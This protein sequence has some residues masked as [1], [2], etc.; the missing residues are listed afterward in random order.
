MANKKPHGKGRRGNKANLRPPWKP[1][2]SGNPSGRP[3]RRPITDGYGEMAREKM[4]PEL[5]KQLRMK[6]GS[7][8]AQA[9]ARAL[10]IKAMKG[11]VRSA[12][13]IRQ[14]I[15]GSTTQ[16]LKNEM[17]DKQRTLEEILE[18]SYRVEGS[19]ENAESF[20]TDVSDTNSFNGPLSSEGDL[21]G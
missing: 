12:T 16:R 7:T 20:A 1:G 15:E 11:D 21:E 9:V 8:F 3:K 18:A 10:F 4:P 17:V 5:C 14:A 13:E 2:Q 19:G 6:P